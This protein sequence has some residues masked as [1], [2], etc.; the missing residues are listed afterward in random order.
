MAGQVEIELPPWGK[1]VCIIAKVGPNHDGR[2]ENA[3]DI[4]RAVAEASADAVKFQTFQSRETV[5]SDKTPLAPYMKRAGMVGDQNELHDVLGLSR[6]DFHRISAECK[7]QGITFLS[8]P[9]DVP[10][11][12]LFYDLDVPLM[13]VPSGQLTNPFL[14][15]VIDQTGLDLIV[16]TGM[17]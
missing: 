7:N 3:F 9:F 6:D 16:S 11:V 1:R 8:T 17:I 15:R 4:L 12:E 10:S 2:I 13:K 14:L 5:V